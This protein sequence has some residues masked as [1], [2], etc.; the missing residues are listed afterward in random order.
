MTDTLYS[1]ITGAADALKDTLIGVRR[2]LHRH[3]ELARA[4][5]ETSEYLRHLLASEKVFEL[6][7]VG[8]TGFCADLVTDA[9]KPWL[10]FRAD[11]DALPIPDEKTATYRSVYPG[12]S[13]SCGHDFHST[14][15]LGTAFILGKMRDRLPANIRFIFQHAEEPIPGGAVDFV[16]AGLLDNINAIVGLHAD[17]DL[18]SGRVG[19]TEGWLTAQSMH[20]QITIDG[21]GGHSAR[22]HETSDPIYTGLAVLNAL[23]GGLY[24]NL[25]NATPFVFTIGKINAGDSY[26]SIA[27]NFSA[28]GTLRIT[29][30][31]QGDVLL[32]TIGDTLAS[33]CKSEQLEYDLKVTKGALPVV[34]D[35]DL[36]EKTRRILDR[37]LEPG[38]ITQATRSMGGE[39]FSAFLAK[40]PGVFLRIGVGNGNFSAPVHSGL[41]DIDERTIDFSVK[42]FAWL[43]IHLLESE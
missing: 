29:D 26:N 15:A 1:Q 30:P 19:L 22:P 24:R 12:R 33:A 38:Q 6:H 41:F 36:T 32:E 39:D 8:E 10:A 40:A 18:L 7:M 35:R 4:E 11:M 23:Y 31:D 28:E 34:N 37:I 5:F 25:N 14:V 16:K 42:L 2:H 20:L 43:L 3:P 9:E 17:P 13:H 27:R 21:P